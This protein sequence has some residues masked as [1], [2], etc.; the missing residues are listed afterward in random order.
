[1][2]REAEDTHGVGTGGVEEHNEGDQSEECEYDAHVED[3]KYLRSGSFGWS[4]SRLVL[5]E[6]GTAVGGAGRLRYGWRE[7]RGSS[8]SR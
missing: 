1:M 2:P 3:L 4:A 6:L 5:F 7:E 8:H